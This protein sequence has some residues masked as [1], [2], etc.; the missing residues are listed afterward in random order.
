[1]VLQGKTDQFIQQGVPQRTLEFLFPRK[2]VE[3]RDEYSIQ[4]STSYFLKFSGR[5]LS[6]ER[7]LPFENHH[8]NEIF[9]HFGVLY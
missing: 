6:R 8:T 9:K 5:F 1:M 4:G 2:Q 3:C 7:Q